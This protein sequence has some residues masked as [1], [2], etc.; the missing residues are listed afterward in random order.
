MKSETEKGE[1]S[2]PDAVKEESIAVNN[3]PYTPNED[4]PEK[5]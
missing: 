1:S 5:K 4:S 2:I 3:N